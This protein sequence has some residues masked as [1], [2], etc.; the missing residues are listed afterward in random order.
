MPKLIDIANQTCSRLRGDENI[1]INC[2]RSIDEANPDCIVFVSKKNTKELKNGN[3]AGA[4]LT[5]ESLINCFHSSDNLLIT[6]NL[7]LSLVKLINIFKSK[8]HTEY[9]ISFPE[10]ILKNTTIG[11]NVK[12]SKD[13][14]LGKHCIIGNNVVIEQNVTVGSYSVIGHNTV[15]GS[16]TVIGENCTI[17]HSVVLGS[18]GFGNHRNANKEWVHIPHIGGVKIG[19]NVSIGSGTCIDRGTL[20][21]TII[22]DGVIIDNLVHIAHNVYIGKNTAIAAKVGIAGSCIIG[23]NNLIGGMVGIIDH[24]STCND[25]TISATSSVTRNIDKPGIYSGIMPTI[26]HQTWMR[27]ALSITKLDKITKNKI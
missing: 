17:E 4:Y 6:D 22:E 10:S 12:I 27:V 24:I 18:E 13:C 7:T 21:N 2:I 23:K 8:N 16:D 9:Y 25:V 1:E 3:K 26:P 11:S 5:T 14:I 19:N 20:K 15:I